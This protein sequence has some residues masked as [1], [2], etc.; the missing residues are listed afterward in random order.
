MISKK[1]NGFDFT[2]MPSELSGILQKHHNTIIADDSLSDLDVLLVSNYLIENSNERAGVN[3]SDSKNLFVNFGRKDTNF[4]VNI[5]NAKKKSLIKELD[6]KLYFLS[7]G[8]KRIRNLLGQ[9]SKSPVY[10]IKSGQ[11]FSAI[12]LFEEFL[13][14]QLD[15]VDVLLCDSYISHISL[16]PFSRLKG[17]IKSL[18]I[19]TSNIRDATQFEVYRKKMAKEFGVP[20]EV[21]INKK[22][23]DRFI[24]FGN[25]CWSLGCSIKDLGNKDTTI[26]EIS[27]VVSS[28]KELFNE[29]WA[30]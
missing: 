11:D 18:K 4:K 13:I 25:K 7:G 29:R 19:L 9:V 5:Y 15:N 20:I 6:R 17:K 16:F 28:M 2:E 8:L 27:E 26:R 3:Y 14:G 23:H 1:N 22:I 12:K 10:V 30:E 21:K 24:I